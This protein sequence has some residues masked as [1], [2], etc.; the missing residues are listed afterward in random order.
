MVNYLKIKR[1]GIIT[2]G[3]SNLYDTWVIIVSWNGLFCS[4]MLILETNFRRYIWKIFV[5]NL[6]HFTGVNNNAF[7]FTQYG[8][9]S[10]SELF[11]RKERRYSTPESWWLLNIL[12]SSVASCYPTCDNLRDKFGLRVLYHKMHA[13]F[14]YS[15]ILK[16]MS[17]IRVSYVRHQWKTSQLT[18]NFLP[19]RLCIC[20]IMMKY[21]R[22]M[23]N[24]SPRCTYNFV[25]KQSK[26][27][28][29]VWMRIRLPG[30]FY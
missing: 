3:I 27:V 14:I 26:T 30:P 5:K 21:K 28:K 22:L 8:M 18:H 9:I 4:G 20:V 10:I 23:S 17:N 29:E 24:Q 13:V 6:G 2:I 1:M 25:E 12:R 7:T 16:K 19:P 11:I 15:H